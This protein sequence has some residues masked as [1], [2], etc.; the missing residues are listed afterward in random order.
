MNNN[1]LWGFLGMAIVGIVLGIG[2]FS[3]GHYLMESNDSE[4]TEYPVK[5]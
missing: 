3:R 1:K 5:L 4:N 2:P